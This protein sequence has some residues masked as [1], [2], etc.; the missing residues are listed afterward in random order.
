MRNTRSSRGTSTIEEPPNSNQIIKHVID[1]VSSDS[2]DSFIGISS[3]YSEKLINIRRVLG[4]REFA[5][6]VG[7]C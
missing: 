5:V 3:C 2:I 6:N 7:E 1:V 4:T